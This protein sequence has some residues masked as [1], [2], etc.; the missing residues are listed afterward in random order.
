MK[1]LFNKYRSQI[2]FLSTY[3]LLFFFL[4]TLQFRMNL[5][6]HEKNS[7]LITFLYPYLEKINFLFEVIFLIV[8][9][10][11]TM[12][13]SKR[14]VRIDPLVHLFAF[15]H[16]LLA[17]KYSFYG[18]DNSAFYIFRDFLLF[19]YYIFIHYF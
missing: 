8:L 19:I 17:F 16:F 13:I 3:S 12:F 11:T 15:F 5:Q 9:F 6:N 7:E 14:R 4:L 10:S 18:I 1:E 2:E